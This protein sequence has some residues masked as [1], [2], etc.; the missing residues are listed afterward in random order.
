MLKQIALSFSN[1]QLLWILF[2]ELSLY[3][4]GATEEFSQ[5][6]QFIFDRIPVFDVHWQTM[7]ATAAFPYWEPLRSDFMAK[8]Q[9]S[10][11]GD[12]ATGELHVH[13]LLSAEN[14]TLKG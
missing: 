6:V 2:A 10:K 4:H 13:I 9:W 1:V 8:A 5:D 11:T 3:C 12:E 7:R 14:F